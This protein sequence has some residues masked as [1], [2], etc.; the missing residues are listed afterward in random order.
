M[1]GVGGQEKAEL[2]VRERS[3]LKKRE[4]ML[5]KTSACRD[6]N[7][8]V[9][10][11]RESENAGTLLARGLWTIGHG[12]DGVCGDQREKSQRKRKC[13]RAGAP[14]SPTGTTA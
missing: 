14:A 6:E 2:D 8:A 12:R 5:R 13:E 10:T 4:E 11:G 9:E 1:C 7:V 3:E